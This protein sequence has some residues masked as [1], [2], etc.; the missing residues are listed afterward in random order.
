MLSLRMSIK[1]TLRNNKKNYKI[2][3]SC[4]FKKTEQKRQKEENI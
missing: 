2:E 1:R 4:M 3:S